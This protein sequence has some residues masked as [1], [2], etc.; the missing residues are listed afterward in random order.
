MHRIYRR[1][2]RASAKRACRRNEASLKAAAGAGAMLLAC[3]LAGLSALETHYVGFNGEVFVRVQFNGP[4]PPH[5]RASGRWDRRDGRLSGRRDRGPR[6]RGDW[7]NG[8]L[9]FERSSTRSGKWLD[10]LSRQ[11]SRPASS[12]SK[13]AP[14]NSGGTGG[15]TWTPRPMRLRAE[16]R[17]GRKCHLDL[18]GNLMSLRN[19][20]VAEKCRLPAFVPSWRPEL[21]FN[22]RT[23]DPVV[24]SA[25]I[26]GL[27]QGAGST[28]PNAR[29]CVGYIRRRKV[30]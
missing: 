24:E 14:T 29:S 25:G 26:N 23:P 15:S 21:A 2:S 18:T 16:D 28:L 13:H 22:R 8:L 1:C 30:E 6:R 19:M 20:M 12:T 5:R 10:G 11:M 7:R 4:H 9:K 27:R 3:R 17:T